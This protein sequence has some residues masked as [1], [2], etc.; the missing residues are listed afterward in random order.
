MK[1]ITEIVKLGTVKDV[2]REDFME[3][4]N[5]L[6]I[7]FHAIQPGYIDTELIID[8]K[9]EEWTMIQHWDSIEN[10]KNASGKMFKESSTEKFRSVLDP[11][12]VK[13]SIHSQI[14]TWKL[15]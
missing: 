5:D 12:K 13:I 4:V 8:E 2:S 1:T 6:E 7:K 9:S 11:Q 3:I 15:E 10:L 14:K